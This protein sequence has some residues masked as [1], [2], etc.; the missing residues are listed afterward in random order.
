[1]AEVAAA[2]SGAYLLSASWD[3]IAGLRDID[4]PGYQ[5]PQDAAVRVRAHHSRADFRVF[6][7]GAGRRGHRFELEHRADFASDYLRRTDGAARSQLFCNC[8]G[9]RNDFAPDAGG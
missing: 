2:A 4:L 7:D 6:S 9:C 1:R 8:I 5:H 3:A